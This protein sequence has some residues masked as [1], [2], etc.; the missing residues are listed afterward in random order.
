MLCADQT[1]DRTMSYT[2]Y[3][4]YISLLSDE[5]TNIKLLSKIRD[6]DEVVS[7][8]QNLLKG[9]EDDNEKETTW[10]STRKNREGTDKRSHVQQL[11]KKENS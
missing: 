1:C 11:L 3:R 5:E 2:V 10:V 7:L 8:I 6:D 9:F 4:Y